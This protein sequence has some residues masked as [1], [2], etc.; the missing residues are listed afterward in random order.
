MDPKILFA[1]GQIIIF[2][3]I[4]YPH[5]LP[6][7]YSDLSPAP[8]IIP[9]P[10]GSKYGS[11]RALQQFGSP[12]LRTPIAVPQLL[13]NAF[14]QLIVEVWMCSCGARFLEKVVDLKLRTAEKLLNRVCG[15]ADAGHISLKSCEYTILKVVSSRF[16][17]AIVDMV[18]SRTTLATFLDQLR[19]SG[20][21]LAAFPFVS[22]DVFIGC[23]Q[24]ENGKLET[25]MFC[26][27]SSNR[28]CFRRI[29]YKSKKQQTSFK[30][31]DGCLLMQSYQ[32]HFQHNSD[33]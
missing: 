19:N 20:D 24:T 5:Q 32:Y 25:G 31:T 3:F 15:F 9:D 7:L 10:N 27:F 18:Q 11:G 21:P 22:P 8:Q 1:E 4:L 16:G 23:V 29:N 26:Q 33:W 14:S 2:I 17:I 13:Y 30:I 28:R 6:I 12:F